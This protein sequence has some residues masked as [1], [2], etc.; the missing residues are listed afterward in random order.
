M[1]QTTKNLHKNLLLT[2]KAKL[3]RQGVKLLKEFIQF[4]VKNLRELSSAACC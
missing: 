4:V 3:V 1:K 2:L